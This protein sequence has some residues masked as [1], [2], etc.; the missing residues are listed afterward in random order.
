MRALANIIRSREPY[1][2]IFMMAELWMEDDHTLLMEA[3]N[4]TGL[5]MTGFREL[6]SRYT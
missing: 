5:Y 6:A 3:A 4:E 2:D 1:F